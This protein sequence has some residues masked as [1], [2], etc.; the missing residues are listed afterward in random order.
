[1]S[2]STGFS[3]EVRRLILE[4]ATDEFGV[5]RCERCG[6]GEHSDVQVHHRLPRR[7]GGTKRPEVNHAANGFVM[8]EACHRW[9]ESYRAKSYDAGWLLR[10][11]AIPCEAAVVYRGEW[12]VLGDD[13]SVRPV[14]GEGEVA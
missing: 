5:L 11:G 7:A 2:R 12:C 13:G 3:P 1:M 8:D 10:S 9:V 14:L 6:S 4:R